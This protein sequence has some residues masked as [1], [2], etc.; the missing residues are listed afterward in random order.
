DD[1]SASS[2]L[3]SNTATPH[4]PLDFSMSS[5]QTLTRSGEI[6][7]VER[8]RILPNMTSVTPCPAPCQGWRSIVY[9]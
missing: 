7:Q 5:P 3:N 4:R 1:F 9:V 2:S 6:G 8:R